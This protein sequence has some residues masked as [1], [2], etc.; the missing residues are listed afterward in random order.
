MDLAGLEKNN[1]I[2]IQVVAS[3]LIDT[4]VSEQDIRNRSRGSRRSL[5][6]ACAGDSKQVPHIERVR[7]LVGPQMKWHPSSNVGLLR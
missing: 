1:R 5:N 3:Y 2:H 4:L 6:A 7:A